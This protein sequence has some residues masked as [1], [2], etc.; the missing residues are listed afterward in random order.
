MLYDRNQIAFQKSD[1]DGGADEGARGENNKMGKEK[2]EKM[3][4]IGGISKSDYD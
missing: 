1:D 3:S 4:K 2:K